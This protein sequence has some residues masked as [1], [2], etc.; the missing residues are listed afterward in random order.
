MFCNFLLAALFSSSN[1]SLD[2]A[3]VHCR[4]ITFPSPGGWLLSR[5]PL[6][7]SHVTVRG[8]PLGPRSEIPR[9]LNFFHLRFS[10]THGF[11]GILCVLQFIAVPCGEE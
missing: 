4:G 9:R 8:V 5:C 2:F 10:L 7:C 6:R 3:Y 1:V 11:V